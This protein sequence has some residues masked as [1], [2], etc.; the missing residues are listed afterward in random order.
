MNTPP[1]SLCLLESRHARRSSRDHA[2]NPALR[3]LSRQ[4]QARRGD[5]EGR[6]RIRLPS[7]ERSARECERDG[8]PEKAASLFKWAAEVR[9]RR[10]DPDEPEDAP[11]QSDLFS[12]TQKDAA[13]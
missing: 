5:M 4:Q 6:R 13:E 12:I 7:D 9:A 3:I 1:R 8:I 11:A 10:D 2:R